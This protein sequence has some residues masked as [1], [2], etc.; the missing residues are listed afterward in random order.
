MLRSYGPAAIAAGH[1]V[2]RPPSINVNQISATAAT[3]KKIDDP[4][5][6]SAKRN[7]VDDRLYSQEVLRPSALLQDRRT[8][9][10]TAA[11]AGTISGTASGSAYS[12]YTRAQL[13]QR[14]LEL[15]RE[16]A[17]LESSGAGSPS[18]SSRTPSASS[19]EEVHSLNAHSSS[20]VARILVN[21]RERHISAPT[22]TYPS[23]PASASGLGLDGFET[24]PYEQ[25]GSDDI[26]PANLPS[27]WGKAAYKQGWKGAPPV[28]YS[29]EQR[30]SIQQQKRSSWFWGGGGAA[31]AS[32]SASP[33]NSNP[34][35]G[36]K[37]D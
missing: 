8:L 6:S 18:A 10:A 13:R 24:S 30:P 31:G 36:K 19:G 2:F 20:S 33:A 22:P 35:Q 7:T 1:A 29:Q 28:S 32:S 15:E 11:L 16:L 14:R 25:I 5:L 17:A 12:S 27:D 4:A 34:G 37:N 23:R 3:L 9:S 26:D 21:S